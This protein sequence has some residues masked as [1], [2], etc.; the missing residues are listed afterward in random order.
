MTTRKEYKRIYKIGHDNAFIEIKQFIEI[1]RTIGNVENIMP[2]G[3]KFLDG[4]S[5]GL[6]LSHLLKYLENNGK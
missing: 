4:F 6:C 2:N 1:E 3:E 5:A